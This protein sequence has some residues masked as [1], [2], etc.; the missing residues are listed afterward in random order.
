MDPAPFPPQQQNYPIVQ[1]P[2]LSD[3]NWLLAVLLCIFLGYLG[4][5]RFYTGRI[6]LGLGLL[7][8]G[9]GFGVWW[10]VDSIIF[11]VGA[12]KD[13]KGLYVKPH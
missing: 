13:D 12:G 4:I 9:G 5:H 2:I 7:I 3:R 10:V 6:A 8:T 1:G 11:L